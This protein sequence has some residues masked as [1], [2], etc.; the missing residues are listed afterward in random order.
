MILK[1]ILFLSLIIFLS[2]CSSKEIVKID[3]SRLHDIWA[4]ESIEGEK[5]QIIEEL[6]NL[7]MIPRRRWR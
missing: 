7:P 4:L 5:I 3:V 2:S 6:M 1:Q